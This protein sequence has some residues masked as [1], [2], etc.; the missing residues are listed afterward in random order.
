MSKDVKGYTTVALDS[1]KKIKN[2]SK[3]WRIMLLFCIPLE[4]YQH[5]LKETVK[6]TLIGIVVS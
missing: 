3:R 1:F 2:G 6:E 5:F 4:E